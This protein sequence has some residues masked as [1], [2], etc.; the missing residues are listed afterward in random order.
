MSHGLIHGSELAPL[1]ERADIVVCGPGIGRS[2][3]GQQMLQQVLDSGKRQVLDADALN[4]MAA[5]AVAKEGNRVLTPHPGEAARLLECSVAEVEAD[6]LGAATRIQKLWGGIVLLK[7]AGTVIATEATQPFV[8]AGGNP[9]MATGGMGDVLSG[10]IGAFLGQLD[11]PARATVSAA[12]AHL[13]AADLASAR[14]GFKA[15]VP[16]DVLEALPAVL[17]QTETMPFHDDRE[18]R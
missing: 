13:A 12:S 11:D 2:A 15:L 6:R 14:V 3:W 4:L 18:A 1:L 8:V 10:M 17:K 5:R 16:A 7:G 9:G